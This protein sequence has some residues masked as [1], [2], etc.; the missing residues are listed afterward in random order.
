MRIKAAV[1]GGA[2]LAASASG[3]AADALACGFVDYRGEIRP[4]VPA[5]KPK[6]VPA[7]DRIA[8]ADQRLEEERL[9]DAAGQVVAAFP[10]IQH[11]VVG[12]SPLE[13]HAMRILALAL[14]RG[15]GSLAGTATFSGTSERQRSAQLDWAVSTLKAVSIDRDDDPVAQANLAEALASRPA[16]EDQALAILDN[17]AARGISSAAPTPTP[18]SRG[19]AA[20]AATRPGFARRSSAAS[21]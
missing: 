4:Y 14:V 20:R 21:S 5:P 13:T 12:L 17:L 16:T 9:A 19:C 6:P 11:A 7:I 2:L 18:R 15:D 1:L 10:H 8:A 3:V